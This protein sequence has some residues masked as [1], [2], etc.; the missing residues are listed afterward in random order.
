MSRQAE[1]GV[2]AGD[3]LQ[4][5]AN[6]RERSFANG[7]TVRLTG[8]SDDRLTVRDASGTSHTLATDD[9]M[10]HHLAHGLVTNMH[11]AQGTTV[12][13]AIAVM[14]SGDRAL[15]SQSLAYVLA[16]RAREGFALHTDNAEQLISQIERNSGMVP[17]AME[18]AGKAA[19]TSE[20]HAERP[21]RETPALQMEKSRDFGLG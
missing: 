9:P 11:R 6:D 7:E 20:S 16:S 12:D 8:I 10:R 19:T 3:V 18:V 21:P 4:W 14:E 13:H 15:N 5:T 17:S 1:I 2:R